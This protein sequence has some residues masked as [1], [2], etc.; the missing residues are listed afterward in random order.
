MS[1]NNPV[2]EII[3]IPFDFELDSWYSEF[4]AN[5]NITLFITTNNKVNLKFNFKLTFAV[6]LTTF[7]VTLTTFASDRD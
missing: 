7:A 5:V 6:T 1:F 4:E 3:V 2:P